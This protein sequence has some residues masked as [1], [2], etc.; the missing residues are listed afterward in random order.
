[1]ARDEDLV[2]FKHARDQVTL[3][4]L[5]EW[6]YIEVNCPSCGRTGQIYPV[7][8]RKRY[9]PD[10]HIAELTDRFRCSRCWTKGSQHWSILKIGRN[11]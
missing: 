3:G 6:H 2:V 9:P 5:R 7:R 1:M 11:D 8:L 4:D 10:T